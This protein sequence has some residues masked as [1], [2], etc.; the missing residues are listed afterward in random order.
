M[1]V[2]VGNNFNNDLAPIAGF[3]DVINRGNALREEGIDDA[4]TT[5][6]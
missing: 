5:L 4:T 3:E 6:M 1:R 2:E